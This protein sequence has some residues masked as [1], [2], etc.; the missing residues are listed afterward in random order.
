MIRLAIQIAH[1]FSRGS[2]HNL[3]ASD[4]TASFIK[5][6]LS[7]DIYQ[8]TNNVYNVGCSV[9]SVN[10]KNESY[11]RSN[12]HIRCESIVREKLVY[13]RLPLRNYFIPTPR[14]R[15]LNF[16]TLRFRSYGFVEYLFFSSRSFSFFFPSLTGIGQDAREWSIVVQLVLSLP[17]TRF[18]EP[19]AV[20]HFA[21]LLTRLHTDWTGS[22]IAVQ[23]G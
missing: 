22:A 5:W 8:I 17:L 15:S 23:A 16:S 20:F 14:F 10:V 13:I 3:I 6:Y 18:T 12:W 9:Y 19:R 7:S 1:T 11:L 2:R 4:F 21:A